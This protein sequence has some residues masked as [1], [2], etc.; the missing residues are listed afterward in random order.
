MEAYRP[1]VVPVI[2]VAVL[3]AYLLLLYQL[4]SWRRRGRLRKRDERRHG[5]QLEWRESGQLPA[6]Y[7]TTYWPDELLDED[8]ARMEELGYYVADEV[9]YA[10]GSRQIVYRLRGTSAL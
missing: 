9:M 8:M 5:E 1:F 10:N 2:I 7:V 4:A 3:L 6:R